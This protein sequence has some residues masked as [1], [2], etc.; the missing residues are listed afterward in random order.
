MPVTVG[1]RRDTSFYKYV[2]HQPSYLKMLFQFKATFEKIKQETMVYK[3]RGFFFFYSGG[4]TFC[5]MLM[6]IVHLQKECAISFL[7]AT[8]IYIA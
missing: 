1:I 2:H 4:F 7:I 6:F 5:T 8:F 3:M